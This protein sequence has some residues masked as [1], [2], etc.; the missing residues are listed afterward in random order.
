MCDVRQECGNCVRKALLYRLGKN[1]QQSTVVSCG[2]DFGR[3]EQFRELLQNDWYRLKAGARSELE[4]MG[5]LG[6]MLL[7]K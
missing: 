3:E 2:Y 1:S 5:Y 4:Q 6:P 7:Y